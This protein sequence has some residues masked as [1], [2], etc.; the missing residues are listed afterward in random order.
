MT[1]AE[2]WRVGVLRDGDVELDIVGG[3]PALELGTDFD[4]V[5][6]AAARVLLD[7]RLGPDER[8]DLGV[9]PVDRK[10]VV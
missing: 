9:E 10:S 5:F 6:D 7:E 4:D 3:A 1:Y 8:L 2:L